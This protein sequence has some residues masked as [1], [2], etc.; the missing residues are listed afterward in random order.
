[1]PRKA[2]REQYRTPLAGARDEWNDTTPPMNSPATT[3]NKRA[4]VDKEKARDERNDTMPPTDSPATAQRE[5]AQ[6]VEEN[7]RLRAQIDAMANSDMQQR[8][9]MQH[10]MIAELRE[11]ISQLRDAQKAATDATQLHQPAS[12]SNNWAHE[13]VMPRQFDGK[14]RDDSDLYSGEGQAYMEHV[15]ELLDGLPDAVKL[16]RLR[17]ALVGDA[18]VWLD[19]LPSG[20]RR[21]YALLKTALINRFKPRLAPEIARA[22]YRLLKQE[23]EM[24]VTDLSA[25]MTE[26]M[27]LTGR[28]K[29][30]TD[31]QLIE[32]M[33]D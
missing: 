15:E 12:H 16:R 4:Q 1:M 9:S 21:N 7:A 22:R 17:Q 29:E 10:A 3:K 32:D 13:I 6:L 14:F 26:L 31:Q 28:N 24:T 23:P 27:R 18:Q 5:R 11:E 33:M 20:T 25:R 8:L 19:T 30:F 2:R